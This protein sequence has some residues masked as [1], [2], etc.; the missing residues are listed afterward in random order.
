MKWI[1]IIISIALV[2]FTIKLVPG[3]AYLWIIGV[4]IKLWADDQD[5]SGKGSDLEWLNVVIGVTG[6]TVFYWVLWWPLS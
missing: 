3:S 2:I 6:I 1:K 5:K 4:F